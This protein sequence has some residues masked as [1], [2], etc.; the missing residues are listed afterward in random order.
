MDK[1]IRYYIKHVYG[2]SRLNVTSDEEADA[3]ARGHF[4]RKYGP[5]VIVKETRE[6][7]IRHPQEQP[8]G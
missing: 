1:D 8:L 4:A 7:I 6:E 3:V 2:R 5:V